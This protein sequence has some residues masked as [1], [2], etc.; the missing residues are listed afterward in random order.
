MSKHFQKESRMI[1]DPFT[2][3]QQAVLQL[4]TIHGIRAVE[5]LGFKRVAE[6]HQYDVCACVADWKAGRILTMK[7]EYMCVLKCV[8]W[9][10]WFMIHS[11]HLP[12]TTSSTTSS[13][14]IW[15]SGNLNV[16]VDTGFTLVIF[17]HPSPDFLIQAHFH[18]HID[19]PHTHRRCIPNSKVLMSTHCTT[20]NCNSSRTHHSSLTVRS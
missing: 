18:D 1:G 5:N 12:Y 11:A 3:I 13:T 14:S 4:I 19:S 10:F 17:N 9:V 2:S 8:Y 15:P 7:N 6:W 16:S 20:G